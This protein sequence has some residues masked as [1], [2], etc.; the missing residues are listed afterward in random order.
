MASTG[1][2]RAGSQSSG[3]MI[4]ATGATAAKRSAMAQATADDI[5]APF[6]RPVAYTREVSMQRSAPSWSS[7]SSV[8]TRSGLASGSMPTFQPTGS[9]VPCGP[10]TTKPCSAA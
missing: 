5:H 9:P 3:R 2:G 1:T 8:N 6:D 4:P 7:R 10:T